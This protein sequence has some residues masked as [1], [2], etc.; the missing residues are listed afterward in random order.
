MSYRSIYISYT[1]YINGVDY[2]RINKVYVWGLGIWTLWQTTILG[3]VHNQFAF[4]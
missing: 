1:D 2:T 4:D 3:T